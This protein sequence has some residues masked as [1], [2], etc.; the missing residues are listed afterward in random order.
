MNMQEL[1]GI[2]VPVID[3][4]GMTRAS[5]RID[6]LLMP[7]HALGKLL[8]L[9]RKVAGITGTTG[10]TSAAR[11]LWSWRGTTASRRKG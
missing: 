11:W 5:E 8:D 6:H 4:A 1:T 2:Q 9:G 7:R 3:E 10:W